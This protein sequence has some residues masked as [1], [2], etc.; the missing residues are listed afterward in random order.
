MK[1]IFK[2][3]SVNRVFAFSVT[4]KYLNR[5]FYRS[6]RATWN[7]HELKRSPSKR[8]NL[9]CLRAWNIVCAPWTWANGMVNVSKQIVIVVAKDMA[10]K[11]ANEL[12]YWN[13]TSTIEWLGRGAFSA[14]PWL[15]FF[16][17]SLFLVD[18][19]IVV[20]HLQYLLN[21]Q[22]AGL[23]SLQPTQMML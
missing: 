23:K 7:W 8:Y 1:H 14:K 16:N 2:Y 11:K 12:F 17:K 6:F 21:L 13:N 20:K 10:D 4:N 18:Y 9:L 15:F 5:L 22:S 19:M 3:A